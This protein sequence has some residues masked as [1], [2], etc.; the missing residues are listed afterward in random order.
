MLASWAATMDQAA[1]A[2][3]RNE[4]RASRADVGVEC[5]AQ[6]GPAQGP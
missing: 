3:G 4:G 1:D 6:N 2:Y 5:G